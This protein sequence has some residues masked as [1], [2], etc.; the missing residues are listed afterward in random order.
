MAVM[1]EAHRLGLRTYAMFCP[2][3]PGISDDPTQ[4]DELVRF[5][6][7][8]GAEEV[9]TEP[10]NPRGPGLRFVQEA[11][12]AAGFANEA[13]AISEIRRRQNWSRY[14]VHLIANIQRSVRTHSNIEFLRILLYPS[15]LDPADKAAIRR[16]D[17]GVVFLGK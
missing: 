5:A 9:F 11:F 14:V 13:A 3:L 10:V 12:R 15:S 1:R 17:K 8:C 2:L 6:V 16:D 7:E 4:I